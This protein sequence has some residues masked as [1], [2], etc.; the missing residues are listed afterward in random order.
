MEYIIY[1]DESD[2]EGKYFGNFY[3]AALVRSKDVDRIEK[4]L[5][6]LKSSLGLDGEMK[7]T[8]VPSNEAYFEKYKKVIDSFFHFIKQDLVKIRIMFTQNKNEPQ[9]LTKEQIANE[10]LL[11]YYQF[12]KHAFGLKY[13]DEKQPGEKIRL[14]FYFDDLPI[15]DIDSRRFKDYIYNLAMLESAYGDGFEIRYEDMAE[16]NSKNHCIMQCLD[17]VLG[18]ITFRLNDKHKEKLP[19]QRIRSKGTVAKEK[20]YKIIYNH[21]REIHSNFNPGISTGARGVENHHWKHSY[22]HW[23]FIPKDYKLNFTATKKYKK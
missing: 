7:W 12:L 9:N 5:R 1:S 3:G 23:L 4:T 15:S 14:R 17:I 8:K 11:L 16:V 13:C 6:D 10:F 2:R 21:I 18:S 19:G 20:M 22:S